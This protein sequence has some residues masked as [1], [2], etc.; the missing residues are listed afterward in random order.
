MYIV[1]PAI[2][3]FLSFFLSFVLPFLFLPFL[4]LSFSFLLLFLLQH[5]VAVASDAAEDDAVFGS[6]RDAGHRSAA[7]VA[8]HGLDEDGVGIAR[9]AA[10][11]GAAHGDTGLGRRQRN[12]GGHQRPFVAVGALAEHG[13]GH[14]GA[15]AVTHL[16]RHLV[17][18]RSRRRRQPRPP[19]LQG[20][21]VLLRNAKHP[22]CRCI[23]RRLGL[24]NETTKE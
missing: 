13:G 9:A 8:R 1:P 24:W 7:V 18:P 22:R 5:L 11:G 19:H 20:V 23:R 2:F 14:R 21:L 17:G 12:I 4:F 6:H 16:K 10:S 3:F 15:A